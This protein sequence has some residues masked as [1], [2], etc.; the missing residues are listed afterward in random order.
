MKAVLT[1]FPELVHVAF[2]GRL[3]ATWSETASQELEAAIRLGRARIEVDLAQVTFISSVGIGVLLRAVQRFRAG[4]AA[5]VALHYLVGE[6][7]S[8]LDLLF[9]DTRF[10]QYFIHI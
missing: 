3:D 8:T 1:D 2:H 5:R 9:A 10:L 7:E 4:H 6:G